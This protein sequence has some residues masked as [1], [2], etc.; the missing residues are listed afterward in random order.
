MLPC[1]GHA[2]RRVVL[3]ILA[4]A[5]GLASPAAGDEYGL[6]SYYGGAFDSLSTAS[7]ERFDM[8]AMTAAH[9][10]L[11]FGT[12]VRVTHL[13][14]GRSTVV[15]INDRGP[16]RR[17]RVLDL[18]YAA[19]RKL[20][21]VGPGVGAVHIEALPGTAKAP[22]STK[23]AHRPVLRKLWHRSTHQRL[24]PIAARIDVTRVARSGA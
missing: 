22:S 17:G 16:F 5:A 8:H 12:L 4:G 3:L 13:A 21:L 2:G 10:S 18:S 7:G 19:A 9:R 24:A 11:P 23:A 14:N 1:L 6:A 20:R 15:R